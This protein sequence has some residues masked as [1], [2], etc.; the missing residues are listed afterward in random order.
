M[1]RATVPFV[2]VF[3]R[4]MIATWRA[5]LV[6]SIFGGVVSFLF[7]YLHL[8]FLL[9]KIIRLSSPRITAKPTRNVLPF[10]ASM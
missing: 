3:R 9:S 6:G 7:K 5:T 8:L 10:S 4:Q 1:F 2:A